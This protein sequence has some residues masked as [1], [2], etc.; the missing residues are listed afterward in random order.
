[1]INFEFV[2]T[3]QC[4]LDC[5]YCYVEKKNTYM[6]VDTF[7]NTH[8]NNLY[9]ILNNKHDR[10]FEITLFGGE[11][12]LNWDVAKHIIEWG[13]IVANCKR[14]KLF[15]NGLLLDEEKVD[16]LRR[17]NVETT[18]SFDGPKTDLYRP[19]T[20]NSETYLKYQE[21]LPLI[22]QLTDR[23]NVMV[24]PQNLEMGE[25]FDEFLTELEMIPDFK[26]V[27]DNI[28][29]KEDVKQFDIE[30]G[31]LCEKYKNHLINTKENC[32]PQIIKYYLQL[33]IDGLYSTPKM[34]C[35]A[36]SKHFTFLPNGEQ[37]ACSR[38][39]SAEFEFKTQD[40]LKYNHIQCSKCDF[41]RYCDK[42]CLFQNMLNKGPIE[43]VCNLYK[44]IAKHI[45]QLNNELM[46]NEQWT[47]IIMSM[48][49]EE[50]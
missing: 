15:T 25:L 44:I 27:R 31:I 9:T 48:I 46:Y 38:Y 43:N 30:F 1:M 21:K 7:E 17:F 3:Q 32:L 35:G 11:P 12:L 4:N 8:L 36:G 26:L 10:E 42:G 50:V 29:T 22:K 2:L 18:I 13:D 39:A 34:Y 6:S 16:I 24:H 47:N 28:W 41:Y 45:I 37:Y 5:K 19:S 49:K 33:L 40:S 14:I 20:N 23:I